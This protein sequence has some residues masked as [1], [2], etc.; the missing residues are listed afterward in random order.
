MPLFPSIF[1]MKANNENL[2]PLFP[3]IFLSHKRVQDAY[4]VN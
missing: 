3:S 1:L 4:L 2:M